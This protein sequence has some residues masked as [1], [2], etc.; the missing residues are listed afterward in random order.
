MI[1]IQ[2]LKLP[3]EHTTDDLYQKAAKTLRIS[4]KQILEL[5]IKKQSIDARKKEQLSYVYTLYVKTEREEQ[6]LKRIHHKDVSIC[7]PKEYEFVLKSVK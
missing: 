2:Q 6:I 5:S 7:H 3:I 1:Q 4:P